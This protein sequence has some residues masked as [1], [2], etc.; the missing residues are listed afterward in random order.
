[1]PS[2]LLERRP[3]IAEAERL[4]AAANAQIGIAISAFYPAIFLSGSGGFESSHPGTWIQ[5]PSSLWSLGGQATELLFDAGQRHALTSAARHT[6]EAQVA[7]YRNTVFQAFDDVENQ[8]ST[9]RILERES[10]VEQQAVA[11][12]QNSFNISNLR[13]KGGVTSYLEV[14]TAEA[15]LLQDQRTAINIRT[16]EFAASVGLVRALGGG[17]DV[18]QLPK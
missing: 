14:L 2:Q 6:Y 13:Y 9:L 10:S 7:D 4:T 5:G 8:L 16:G 18:T 11:A 15:T 17:W 3:D 12:A 1:V